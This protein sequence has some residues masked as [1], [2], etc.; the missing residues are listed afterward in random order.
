[1]A[2]LVCSFAFAHLRPSSGRDLCTFL[3]TPLLVFSTCRAWHLFVIHVSLCPYCQINC[4]NSPATF[5]DV[6]PRCFPSGLITR[7][8]RNGNPQCFSLTLLLLSL[9]MP[10]SPRTS[11]AL[12]LQHSLEKRQCF[13]SLLGLF[14]FLSLEY[15]FP[16]PHLHLG[17]LRFYPILQN[18][19]EI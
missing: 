19:A 7:Q 4:P 5:C 13:Q 3:A 17:L 18:Q 11:A 12:I 8:R 15:V 1:M 9:R 2:G 10:N 6:F 14:C 16:P